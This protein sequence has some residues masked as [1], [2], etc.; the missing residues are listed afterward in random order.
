MDLG[1]ID[2]VS[3]FPVLTL[4]DKDNPHLGTLWLFYKTHPVQWSTASHRATFFGQLSVSNNTW[5]ITNFRD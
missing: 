1:I 5:D 2:V 3:V 4:G